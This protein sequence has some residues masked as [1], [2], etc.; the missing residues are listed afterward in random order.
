MFGDFWSHCRRS[1]TL[2]PSEGSVCLHRNCLKL[3]LPWA[4]IFSLFCLRPPPPITPLLFFKDK[5]R[6]A[7]CSGGRVCVM[8][9]VKHRPTPF[10]SHS[11][12]MDR[13]CCSPPC[14]NRVCSPSSVLLLWKLKQPQLDLEQDRGLV[15]RKHLTAILATS[16]QISASAPTAQ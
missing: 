7:V 8:T 9:W 6:G 3:N 15:G 10:V 1:L 2:W 11:L 14:P 4:C 5:R 16:G 12:P 13:H